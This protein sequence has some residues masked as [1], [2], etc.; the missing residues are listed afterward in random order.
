MKREQRAW[1]LSFSS[2]KSFTFILSAPEAFYPMTPNTRVRS[3]ADG[4]KRKY[5]HLVLLV[6]LRSANLFICLC[7]RQL[8]KWTVWM[9][10]RS[11]EVTAT[12]KIR[13]KNTLSFAFCNQNEQR[14]S[15]WLKSHRYSLCS[16][17]PI[18]AQNKL[19]WQQTSSR[20]ELLHAVQ[21]PHSWINIFVSAYRACYSN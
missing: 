6:L 2:I 7:A 15:I 20:F 17:A 8:N 13:G 3:D 16:L 21:W 11:N 9:V 19:W 1:F 14:T 5:F 4:S 12:N 18:C 10:R